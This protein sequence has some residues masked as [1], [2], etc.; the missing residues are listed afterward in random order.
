MGVAILVLISVGPIPI[1]D[2]IADRRIVRDYS[3]R[4]TVRGVSAEERSLRLHLAAAIKQ[5]Y[6]IAAVIGTGRLLF[7]QP[8]LTD[9]VCGTLAAAPQVYGLVV[10]ECSSQALSL[11]RRAASDIFVSC[12]LAFVSIKAL[13]DA[14]SLAAISRCDAG[15]PHT[16]PESRARGAVA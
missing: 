4:L 15:V 5:G 13:R 16:P 10:G 12:S 14:Q 3:S 7:R 1:V 9:L 2:T 6:F 11:V 8:A